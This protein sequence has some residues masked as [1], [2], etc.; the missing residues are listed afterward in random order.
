M[1]LK[2][3]DGEKNIL[4]I[5]GVLSVRLRQHNPYDRD[6]QNYP[7]FK[8]P[9]GSVPVLEATVMLHSI[10]HPDW[11]NMT[12]GIPLAMLKK[13][14]GQHEVVLNFSGARWTMYVDG[15]LLDNDFPF[16]YPRW[17]EKNAWKLDAEYVNK[18]ALYL[19]AITPE[20]QAGEKARS[21]AGSVLDAS[22]TQQLGR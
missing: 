15:E 18:A 14:A 10:E 9:D 8:M 17:A 19:P 6:R 2:K 20:Q 1:D 22:R 7:A 3:V 11:K 13:P 21:C 4:E 12:I 16:G 5:P